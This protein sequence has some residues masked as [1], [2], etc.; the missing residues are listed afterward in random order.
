[1]ALKDS[2]MLSDQDKAKRPENKRVAKP[3]NV[4][5]EKGAGVTAETL[6]ITIPP[7][8]LSSSYTAITSP[9]AVI[10]ND[11]MFPVSCP[12]FYES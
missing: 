3:D 5:V 9:T 7:S 4:D 12:L 11:G 8:T 10:L 2:R 1:M 6:T